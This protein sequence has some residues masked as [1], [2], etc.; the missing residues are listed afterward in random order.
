MRNFLIRS[1]VALVGIPALLWIFYQGTFY[2][3]GLVLL[4]GVL[5]CIEIW[6]AAKQKELP[7][8]LWLLLIL[9]LSIPLFIWRHGGPGWVSWIV[10]AFIA[11]G[12]LAAWRRDAVEAVLVVMIHLTI[13]LWLGIGLAAII[14]LRG[15]VQGDLWLVFLFANLWIGDTAAYLGGVS[16]GGPKLSPVISPNK[17]VSGSISQIIA[18]G[19]VAGGFL[20]GGWIAAPAGLLVTAA[21][22]I[23][24]V[25]Q[26]G[27]LFESA[28][29]RAVGV[30]DFSSLIPGHGGVLDRFDS[31]F[32]AAPAL[33]VLIYFWQS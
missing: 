10:T 8:R 12:L 2:L 33:W 31:A 7:V 32:F 16:I 14:A 27:D 20:A 6:R 15:G 4:I 17:T 25:G 9:T 11:T 28:L 23:A 22:T 3:R 24:V 5:G 26:L 18:S 30:K 1:L 29:K 21:L 19:L 13:A